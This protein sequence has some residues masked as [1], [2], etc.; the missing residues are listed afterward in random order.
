MNHWLDTWIDFPINCWIGNIRQT[1]RYMRRGERKS[2]RAYVS[3]KMSDL[4][5][6]INEQK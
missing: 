2:V 1:D 3:R 4:D 5:E 6:K